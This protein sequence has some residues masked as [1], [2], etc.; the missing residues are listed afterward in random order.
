MEP[1][2]QASKWAM[3]RYQEAYKWTKGTIEAGWQRRQNI[4]WRERN[5]RACEELMRNRTFRF[6]LQRHRYETLRIVE[7]AHRNL[8][9]NSPSAGDP[10]S[11]RDVRRLNLR[12]RHLKTLLNRQNTWSIRDRLGGEYHRPSGW[13]SGNM[14]PQKYYGYEKMMKGERNQ[15]R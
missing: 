11:I 14:K 9:Y 5:E 6:K 13:R 1:R 10:D 7:M 8:E 15:V 2:R 12:I 3:S 4:G